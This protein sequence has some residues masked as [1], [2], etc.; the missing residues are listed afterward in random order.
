MTVSVKRL[1][2]IVRGQSGE[3][4]VI[5]AGAFGIDRFYSVKGMTGEWTL[6]YPG[7]D[8]MTHTEG[9]KTQTAARVAAQADYETRTRAAVEPT[10]PST[11]VVVSKGYAL[12]P[13][14][15]TDEVIEAICQ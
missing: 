5:Y 10:P 14:K 15:P 11:H 6:S 4:P 12:I 8:C 13:I 2:W 1:E 9:F 7:S 3:L